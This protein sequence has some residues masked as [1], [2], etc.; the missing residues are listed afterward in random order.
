[1]SR[2]AVRSTTRIA[3][4][5]VGLAVGEVVGAG[6]GVMRGVGVAGGVGVDVGDDVGVGADVAEL[7]GGVGVTTGI[8]GAADEQAAARNRP[9]T[10]VA[11]NGACDARM[12]VPSDR[13][14]GGDV[15]LRRLLRRM[16]RVVIPGPRPPRS[17]SRS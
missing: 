5:D 10:I 12:C 15:Q 13:D 8:E 6:I 9:T 7:D 3:S 14:P 11:A 16:T 17:I 4:R 2:I 1:M